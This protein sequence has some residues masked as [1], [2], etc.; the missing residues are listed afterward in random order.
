MPSIA[1]AR[2][3]A[4]WRVR[5]AAGGRTGHEDSRHRRSSPTRAGPARPR[6]PDRPKARGAGRPPPQTAKP[7][8]HG[9]RPVTPAGHPAKRAIIASADDSRAAVMARYLPPC[10]PYG[11]VVN[12]A[13]RLL[14]SPAPPG[15]KRRNFRAAGQPL[16]AGPRPRGSSQRVVGRAGAV[17]PP[18]GLSAPPR[19]LVTCPSRLPAHRRRNSTEISAVHR[20]SRKNYSPSLTGPLINSADA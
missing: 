13:T 9:R 18:P 10:R 8:T 5:P 3:D 15:R 20:E 4:R 17:P 14:I 11:R 7:G 19:R 12:C 2:A 1:R 16:A 6:R